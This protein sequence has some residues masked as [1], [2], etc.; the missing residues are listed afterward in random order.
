MLNIKI[1][2]ANGREPVTELGEVFD[3]LFDPIGGHIISSRFGAQ[4]EVIAD[5]LFEGTVC[6]VSTNDGVGQ[7][8]VFNDGLKL[9]LVVLG[10]LA[11]ENGGDLAGLADG[12]VG[13]QQSL[14]QLIQCGAPVKDQLVTIFDLG[15]KEPVL[16]AASFAFAFLEEGSQAG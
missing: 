15:E 4:A 8:E 11:T 12:A 1:I 3:G 5:V 16:T 10:D 6:V 14:V 9:S 13:V 7:I 2:V